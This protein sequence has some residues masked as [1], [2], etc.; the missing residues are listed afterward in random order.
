[1]GPLGGGG[2]QSFPHE[3][4]HMTPQG[5][6]IFCSLDMMRGI[7]HFFWGGAYRRRG[8]QR[9]RGKWAFATLTPS[10]AADSLGDV[11]PQGVMCGECSPP[12]LVRSPG[13]RGAGGREG[14]CHVLKGAEHPVA[15]PEPDGSLQPP[16][17]RGPDVCPMP[18][19]SLHSPWSRGP[20]GTDHNARR[21][22][23]ARAGHGTCGS[24][25]SRN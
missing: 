15:S 14:V 5:V 3:D 18:R 21:A 12:L 8:Y 7:L 17:G 23:G 6:R 16:F 9:S 25:S 22:P 2:C 11:L 10:H 13:G 19:C 4:Y 20:P 24:L 1:M